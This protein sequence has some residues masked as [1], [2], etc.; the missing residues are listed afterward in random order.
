VSIIVSKFGGSSTADASMFERIGKILSA[1]PERR[2][3]VLSAPGASSF[4][5]DK[6]TNLL[7]SCYDAYAAGGDPAPLVDRIAERF[8]NISKALSLTDFS[9]FAHREVTSSLSVSRDHT[10]S[11]GEYLCALLFSRWSGIPMADAADLIY[12]RKDGSTDIP[13]T[14]SAIRRMQEKHRRAIIPGFYGS[15]PDGSIHTFPR[16]GSDITGALVAAG[17]GADL[18]E[19]WSDVDGFMTAD[20]RIVSNVVFNPNLSYRQMRSLSKEGAQV[21]HPDCLAP[22]SERGIPTLLKNTFDPEGA[23]TLI[24]DDFSGSVPCVTGKDDFRIARVDH[25][26]MKALPDGVSYRCLQDIS[27]NEYVLIK[28]SDLPNSS[29]GF[30]PVACICAFGVDAEKKPRILE[31]VPHLHYFD[32]DGLIRFITLRNDFKSAVRKIHR[33]LIG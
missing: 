7:L 28:D 17:T 14:F 12:F 16:N 32:E 20:P 26:C 29:S 21:L 3:I 19:N 4:V 25:A 27:G 33:I 13:L 5:P 9:D 22:V 1:H 6:I 2:Y 10:A 31:S 24:S 15:M 30:T 8:G 18:Y 23:G 11:R